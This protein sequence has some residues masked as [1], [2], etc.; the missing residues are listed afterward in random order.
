MKI[1]LTYLLLLLPLL[2]CNPTPESIN[3]GK[4]SC[5]H[6]KML[7]MDQKWGAEIVTSKGKI[8]KF[9]DLN[10]LVIYLQESN[11][12]SES[13][14]HLLVIDYMNPGQLI[15]AYEAWYIKSDNL[16]SPMASGVAAVSTNTAMNL[17][18]DE[19]GGVSM[20]WDEAMNLFK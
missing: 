2:S 10:C 13:I 18:I 4:D 8:F 6:C 19:N 1:N 7:I 11:L 17:F 12:N 20:N 5:V 15:N 3:F 9:D 16:R 14:A